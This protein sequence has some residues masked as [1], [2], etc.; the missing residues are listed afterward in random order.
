MDMITRTTAAGNRADSVDAVLRAVRD[1]LAEAGVSQP[2]LDA[3]LLV[4]AATGL[5]HDRLILAPERPVTAAER[6]IL[7]SMVDRR[8]RREP[9]SRIL[10]TR[11]FWGRDF[12]VTAAT[13]D[14]RPDSETL[15]E[16]AV[17]WLSRSGA[18]APVVI[19]LGTGTG[20]LLISVLGEVAGAW[21]IGIDVDAAAVGV[22][23][24]NSRRHLGQGRASFLC[25]DWLAPVDMR[26]DAILANPPYIPSME[27]EGLADEV[28]LFDPRKALD[29]GDD[30]LEAFR[31]IADGAAAHLKPGGVLV[32][33]IGDGQAP[34]VCDIVERRGL[35][36][37]ERRRDLAGKT[38]CICAT[39]VA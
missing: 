11:E 34:A 17:E 5:S 25:A 32:F 24:R 18:G 37:A 6:Q 7:E 14:P 12:V 2:A 10:G 1:R 28:A 29:G 31:R 19:D 20:C 23:D 15:V 39:P 3:R 13:L 22:A 36:V 4:C 27:I 38:R 8:M 16:A 35:R 26:V 33:E 21:G 30:G 9:V